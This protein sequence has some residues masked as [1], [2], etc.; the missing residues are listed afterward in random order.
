[1][2]RANLKRAAYRRAKFIDIFWLYAVAGGLGYLFIV[3]LLE[4]I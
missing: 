1:M 2:I 4:A 3:S